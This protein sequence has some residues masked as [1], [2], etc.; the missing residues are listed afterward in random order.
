MDRHDK[1]I[2][3]IFNILEGVVEV[4]KDNDEVLDKILSGMAK[5]TDILVGMQDE[6]DELKKNKA[7]KVVKEC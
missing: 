6:I 2:N 5:I 4:T 7:D 3:D 1:A